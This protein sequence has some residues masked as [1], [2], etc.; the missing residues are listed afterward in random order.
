MKQLVGAA[1]LAISTIAPAEAV[2]VTRSFT[3]TASTFMQFAGNP[4]PF[5]SLVADITV[6]YDPSKNGFYGAPDYFRV[7]TDG[8]I[9]AGP[10]AATPIAGYFGPNA[11][12]STPRLG[13]GGALNGGNVG[14]PGT[15]DFYIVFNIDPVGASSVSF[16]LATVPGA[17]LS[18]NATVVETTGTSAVPEGGTW[19]MLLAGSAL[20]GGALRRARK[21]VLRA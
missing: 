6:T 10:F 18:T 8:Q 7:V 2:T 13:I 17:F 11:L 20:A 14:L 4:A 3:V 19:M 21:R 12:T 1:V 16:N 9:N 5:K 15:D